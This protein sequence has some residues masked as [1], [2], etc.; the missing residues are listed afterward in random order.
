MRFSIWI[1]D[2]ADET[3]NSVAQSKMTIVETGSE[4]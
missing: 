2:F 1:T 3:G 4:K